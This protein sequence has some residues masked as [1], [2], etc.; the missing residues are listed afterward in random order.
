VEAS[1]AARARRRQPEL[2]LANTEGGS[3]EAPA[4]GA[5]APVGNGYTRVSKGF[6]LTWYRALTWYSSPARPFAAPCRDGRSA[7]RYR[8]AREPLPRVPTA[9]QGS[10]CVRGGFKLRAV[11]SSSK[12]PS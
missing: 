3:A 6:A 7:T 10:N 11:P 5:S 8:A 12:V 4:A 9:F 2:A 1:L